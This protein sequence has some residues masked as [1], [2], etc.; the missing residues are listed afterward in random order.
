MAD[1][2]RQV[3]YY[4]VTVPDRPGEASKLLSEVKKAGVNLLAY[5]SFPTTGGMSQIDFVPEDS[6]AFRQASSKLG[7]KLSDRKR[8][9]LVRGEDQVGA[10][11][12]IHEKIAKGGIN[13]TAATA[14]GGG[15]GRYGMILWVK[16]ADQER[17]RKAF[18]I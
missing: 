11:A 6:E 18:G 9:F 2:V 12:D 17:A 8:A 13:L 4:Y 3:D 1:Q 10:V 14:A 16:P 15:S 5:H 7:W